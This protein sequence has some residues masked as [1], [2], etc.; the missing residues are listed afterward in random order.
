MSIVP[1]QRSRKFDTTAPIVPGKYL[2]GAELK[3]SDFNQSS[4][5]SQKKQDVKKIPY[6]FLSGM[7]QLS[8]DR[9]FAEMKKESEGRSADQR[10][11]ITNEMCNMLEEQILRTK[12]MVEK[13]RKVLPDDLDHSNPVSYTKTLQEY[14][15]PKEDDTA[16]LRYYDNDNVSSRPRTAAQGNN[17]D[18]VRVPRPTTTSPTARRLAVDIVRFEIKKREQDSQPESTSP[19]K[20]VQQQPQSNNNIINI[21]NSSVASTT[22]NNQNQEYQSNTNNNNT[23]K[24]SFDDSSTITT[25]GGVSKPST[26]ANN[27]MDN[28][29]TSKKYKTSGKL[30][31]RLTDRYEYDENTELDFTKIRQYKK[32]LHEYAKNHILRQADEIQ[33]DVKN[34]YNKDKFFKPKYFYSKDMAPPF[35]VNGELLSMYVVECIHVP[36]A[37]PV[38]K[39]INMSGGPDARNRLR[40]AMSMKCSQRVVIDLYW[41]CHLRRFQ[42]FKDAYG[43]ILPEAKE[44]LRLLTRRISQNYAMLM[45]GIKTKNP[46]VSSLKDFIFR[47][48]P[49]AVSQAIVCGFYYLCPGSRNIVEKYEWQHGVWLDVC[50]LLSGIDITKSTVVIMRNT[51]F[52]NDEAEKENVDDLDADLDSAVPSSKRNQS[53][54]KMI[55]PT[56]SS[57]GFTDLGLG[58]ASKAR[59]AKSKELKGRIFAFFGFEDLKDKKN[60]QRLIDIRKYLKEEILNVGG[61]L[62]PH[63]KKAN[64]LIRVDSLYKNEYIKNAMKYN[65][66]LDAMLNEEIMKSSNKSGSDG[67]NTLTASRRKIEK[68][69]RNNSLTKKIFIWTSDDLKAKLSE[70]KKKRERQS[71]S[72]ENFRGKQPRTVFQGGH[73]SPWCAEFLGHSAG[74]KTVNLLRTVPVE[75]CLSGGRNTYHP[76]G[77]DDV[78][79]FI[80]KMQNTVQNN[81]ARFEKEKKDGRVELWNELHRLDGMTNKVLYENGSQTAKAFCFDLRERRREQK[82]EKI[83]ME[84][85]KKRQAM[86]KK[87]NLEMA[88]K[89]HKT[90]KRLKPKAKKWAEKEGLVWN[91]L[92]LH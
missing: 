83:R 70:I 57:L 80:Q 52:G 43:G 18:I 69:L 53:E 32:L 75:N 7:P 54:K 14:L 59:V 38:W 74:M 40:K 65:S 66:R 42:P 22:M 37:N 5:E 28:T 85:E 44:A 64:C 61:L 60:N 88:K 26:P 79:P 81:R 3:I 35:E 25:G 72:S 58:G 41:Y 4:A 48:Y 47:F 51:L 24:V 46:K 90:V 21:R 17:D 62:A 45:Q 33:Y 56:T 50:G 29:S 63:P 15:P 6:E 12:R 77:M 71:K 84:K 13:V 27:N 39:F 86:V 19:I 89:R 8:R 11:A 30:K 67:T 2:L 92:P 1:E 73:V 55:A 87:A 34:V 23:P 16:C 78:G 10:E 68:N 76:V 31:K 82:L 20:R 91:L 36:C 49:F 9:A